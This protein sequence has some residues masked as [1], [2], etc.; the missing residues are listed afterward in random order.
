MLGREEDAADQLAA[1]I[2]LRLRPAQAR[3]IID[4]NA[5]LFTS[6]AAEEKAD[7]AVLADDH[8]LMY[9]RLYNLLCLAYGSNKRA[10]GYLVER[11]DL[12]NER[13][14]TCGAEYD[15]AAFAMDRLFHRHLLGGR[16]ARERV[17]RGFRWAH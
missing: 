11:G 10:F 4:G 16:M 13:A 8:S 9:Q 1:L 6:Y 3:P 15:Q 2:L 17:R 5:F 7:R 14:R 12:P